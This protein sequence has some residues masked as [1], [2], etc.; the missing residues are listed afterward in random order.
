MVIVGA[1]KMIDNFDATAKDIQKISESLTDGATDA[2][3]AKL[4]DGEGLD[5]LKGISKVIIQGCMCCRGELIVVEDQCVGWRWVQG[6]WYCWRVRC[7][8]SVGHIWYVY[9]TIL[10]NPIIGTRS[11]PLRIS[12]NWLFR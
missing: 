5:V 8:V 2:A 6:D 10:F 11:W 7:T 1:G 3:F 9:W 12:L 4:D